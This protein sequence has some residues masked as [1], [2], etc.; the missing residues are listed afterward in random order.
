MDNTEVWLALKIKK[1]KMEAVKHRVNI[2]AARGYYILYIC[3]YTRHE[4]I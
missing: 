1:Q 3:T 4:G 2:I